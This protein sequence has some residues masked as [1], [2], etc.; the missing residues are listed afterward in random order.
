MKKIFQIS[1]LI[2]TFF[3]TSKLF[4]MQQDGNSLHGYCLFPPVDGDKFIEFIDD[5]YNFG[6]KNKKKLSTNESFLKDLHQKD[7]RGETPLF[8]LLKGP[9]VS[10]KLVTFLLENGAALNDVNKFGQTT[11]F[12]YLFNQEFLRN[13]KF[14]FDI[15]CI[16]L[17]NGALLDSTSKELVEKSN[18][19]KKIIEQLIDF[20]DEADN[21]I[22]FYA[23][24][25][26]CKTLVDFIEYFKNK[27]ENGSLLYNEKKMSFWSNPCSCDMF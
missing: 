17:E 12:V 14:D 19:L 8:N 11:L 20:R 4:S 15:L 26:N 5:A 7:S 21:D 24:Y 9:G 6:F 13:L 3:I 23:K 16:L 1:F 25:F 27:H 10:L 22:L 18:Y 2:L